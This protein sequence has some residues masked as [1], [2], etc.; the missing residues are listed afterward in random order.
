MSLLASP[1]PFN[2]TSELDPRRRRRS[3]GVSSGELFDTGVLPA[4]DDASSGS[5]PECKSM[6]EGTDRIGVG[7]TPE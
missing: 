7:G 3:V 4:D 5:K 2:E 6:K 1:S